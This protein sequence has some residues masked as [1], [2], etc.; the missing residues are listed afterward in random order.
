[1]KKCLLLLLTIFAVAGCTSCEKEAEPTCPPPPESKV[2]DYT[3]AILPLTARQNDA[4][5]SV[6]RELELDFSGW[7]AETGIAVVKDDYVLT[8][9]SDEVLELELYYPIASCWEEWN[10]AACKVAVDSKTVDYKVYT[11][12][13]DQN[14]SGSL[15]LHYGKYDD[16]YFVG[17]GLTHIVET[18]YSLERVFE[19]TPD[20]SQITGYRY[21]I[22]NFK[23]RF[24]VSHPD[25]SQ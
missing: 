15:N 20:L 10:P 11:A 25:T 1:M 23:G 8:N 14:P 9:P 17:E 2:V 18:C 24:L 13:P 3:G 6:Q 22:C 21:H 5:L 7:D 16:A 4:G 12:R 19:S